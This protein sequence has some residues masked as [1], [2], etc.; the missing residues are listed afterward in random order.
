MRLMLRGLVLLLVGL[1]LPGPLRAQQSHE[2]LP[3]AT[4]STFNTTLQQYLLRESGDRLKDMVPTGWVVSGGTHATAGSLTSAAFATVAYSSNGHYMSQASTAIDYSAVGC[5]TTDVAWVIVTETAAGA[6]SDN[7]T[8]VGSTRYAVN[9]TDTTRPTL[10]AG[11]AWLMYVTLTSSTIAQVTDLRQSWW[12][13]DLGLPSN[14]HAETTPM[15]EVRRIQ[16]DGSSPYVVSGCAPAVPSSSLVLTAF[17]CTAYVRGASGE[18]VYVAQPAAT[19]TYPDVTGVHWLALH[20]DTTSTVSGWT[21]RAGSHYLWQTATSPPA[22]P[23]GGVVIA[24]VTIAGSV[25]TVVSSRGVRSHPLGI[26]TPDQF[27]GTDTARVQAAFDTGRTVQFLRD[28]YVTTVKMGGVDQEIDF[29]GFRLVGA[30]T[31]AQDAVLQLTGRQLTL[32]NLRVDVKFN[33]NYGGCYRWHSE[34]VGAGVQPAQY[35]NIYG[36]HCANARYGLIFGATIGNASVSAAQSESTVYGFTVRA[37]QIPYFG[38]QTNGFLVLVSPV[39]DCNPYEWFTAGGGGVTG[40]GAQDTWY[41]TSLALRNDVGVLKTL[42]GEIL[43]PST[44]LG[45][46]IRGKDFWLIAPTIELRGPQGYLTGSG[47]ITDVSGGAFSDDTDPAWILE[48]GT[49]NGGTLRLAN[50]RLIRPAGVGASSAALF[51]KTHDDGVTD[52]TL[53]M[54]GGLLEEWRWAP[55]A[56]FAGAGIHLVLTQVRFAGTF[57]ALINYPGE[58]L[59]E[60]DPSG[61]RF[62]TALSVLTPQGNWTYAHDSGAGTY[63]IQQAS[64]TGYPFRTVIQFVETGASRL[65][66]PDG[67]RGILMAPSTPYLLGLWSNSSTGQTVTARVYYYNS[68]GVS[69]SDTGNITFR[70]LTTLQE[71]VVMVVSPAGTTFG[72][73]ELRASGAQTAQFAGVRLVAAGVLGTPTREQPVR[74][75]VTSAT[76]AFPLT[77]TGASSD[78]TILLP[79]VSTSPPTPI[80]LGVE[81]PPPG[82]CSFMA[83]VTAPG[84]VTVR[85]LN[86]SGGNVTPTA[87]FFRVA[88]WLG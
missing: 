29:N 56:V 50:Y 78:L 63:G 77:A 36:M 23:S 71:Q 52:Y 1:L 11:S 35:I 70:N 60:S 55:G 74:M 21:R 31:S 32:H 51:M 37:V 79:G 72:V 7:F 69:I 2:T 38:N 40:S 64:V 16:G 67:L 86:N 44:P 83:F 30:A 33:S 62:D 85:F 65:H 18:L 14:T 81:V 57:N 45:Y 58:N 19:V 13:P 54:E 46:G 20:R 22:D 66:T 9:C 34:D 61:A 3:S 41:T 28:Y 73:V 26:V 75:L 47:T 15:A 87:A 68:G 88:A 17:A 43:K 84:V 59:L 80:F 27:T 24:Q 10:P 42:G 53:L 76:L 6:L 39:L 82:N 25:I 5:S 4:T 8:R 49:A 12:T 48:N